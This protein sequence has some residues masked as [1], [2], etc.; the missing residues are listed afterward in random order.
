MK[1]VLKLFCTYMASL[2]ATYEDG[3][4]TDQTKHLVSGNLARNPKGGSSV[5]A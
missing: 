4:Q 5:G 1:N 2:L 3:D